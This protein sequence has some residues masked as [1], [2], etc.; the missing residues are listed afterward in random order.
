MI[1]ARDKIISF[2]L[3][4]KYFLKLYKIPKT[5]WRENIGK[6][7]VLIYGVGNGDNFVKVWEYLEKEGLL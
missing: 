6:E 5:K 2:I 3:T 1:L 4:R 7:M